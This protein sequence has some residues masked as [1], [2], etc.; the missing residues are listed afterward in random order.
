[1]QLNRLQISRRSFLAS[2]AAACIAGLA[3]AKTGGRKKRPNIVFILAD[4]MGYADT[5]VYGQ[6]KFRTPNIDKLAADGLRFID[7]YAGAP[8][9]APSRSALMTGQ[10]TG[11]T[12]VRDNF[13]LAA[14]H[15]GYKGKQEI[16]RASLTTEDKT[17]ADYLK[18]AGYRT[19]LAGKWH[20]DGYDPAAVPNR[21][22]FDWFRG[23]LT[24]TGTTQGYYPTQWYH[25]EELIDVPE[26][27]NDK[28]GLYETFLVT[29]D[30]LDFLRESAKDDKPFFLYVAYSA[31][32]SP[33]QAPDFGSYA[34]EPWDDDEKTYAAMIEYLDQGV[35]KLVSSLKELGLEEDT[36]VFFA[37]DNGPRS[38]PTPQQTKVVNFFDS[39]GIL[40]GYKRDMYEGGIRD[41]LIVRWPG[42][43]A[44]GSTTVSPT[45]FPDFLPTALALAGAPPEAT[46]GVSIVPV[47][48]NPKSTALDDRLMY[49]EFYEP[50]YRQAA[51][52]G[53]WKA[54]RLKR[55][56]PLEL[57]D[58]SVDPSEEHN[59]AAQ[60]PDIVKRLDDYTRQS[61]H[62]SPEYPGTLEPTA[63]GQP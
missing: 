48:R 11:H 29:D 47:L 25:N 55:D 21:H 57:Y 27:A 39:H 35:G 33:Y 17:V 51:R 41:P 31:P 15:V 38:E 2:S 13:A 59:I 56:A 62:E 49:W 23:W 40:Q 14:G 37:S 20:L 4:D 42:K 43:V 12:R 1:M 6:K 50:V 46:D 7:A 26:N 32:H 36:V 5:S 54:V 3:Q 63:S 53:K 44:A 52:W 30:S 9:C 16:R 28:R 60:H 19:G 58:L 61:H 18:A 8:V 34:N 24:Q 22:G 10:N 45:Y